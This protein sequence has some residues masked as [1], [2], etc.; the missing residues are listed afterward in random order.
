MIRDHGPSALVII[1]FMPLHGTEMEKNRPPKPVDIARV[2]ASARL[3][4]SKTPMALGCMRPKGEHRVETDIMAI[5]AGVDAVAFPT[6]EAIKFAQQSGKTATFSPLCCS[7]IYI[8]LG[9]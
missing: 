7:Q 5:K 1:A 9:G 2:I 6:E 4:F 3:M 8:D